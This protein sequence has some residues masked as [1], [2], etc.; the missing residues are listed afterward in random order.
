M[1]N[2]TAASGQVEILLYALQR[3]FRAH[4]HDPI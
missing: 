3:H 4:F 2:T 1:K